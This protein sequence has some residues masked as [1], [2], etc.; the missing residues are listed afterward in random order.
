VCIGYRIS[1]S[2]YRRGA[3][4]LFNVTPAYVF[5]VVQQE[6]PH[7]CS[8]VGMDPANLAFGDEQVE[9]GLREWRRCVAADHW[10]A[11]PTRVCYPEVP[12]WEVARWQERMGITDEQGIPYDISKLFPRKEAA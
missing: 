12:A 1:A 10:P 11:Y 3:R 7:L 2:F 8:L 6:P 5:L 4:A 9:Q